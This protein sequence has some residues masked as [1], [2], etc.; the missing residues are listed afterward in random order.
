MLLEWKGSKMA[1]LHSIE[2]KL[3]E[4]VSETPRSPG[5]KLTV[6]FIVYDNGRVLMDGRPLTD[7][8]KKEVVVPGGSVEAWNVAHEI[9]AMYMR[10]FA[11]RVR[12]RIDG[13]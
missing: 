1:T 9:F 12:A 13:R 8:D 3:N 10:L 4:I 6:E 11:K 5:L 2:E 7:Q